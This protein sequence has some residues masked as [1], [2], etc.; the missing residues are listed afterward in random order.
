MNQRKR[1]LILLAFVSMALSTLYPLAGDNNAALAGGSWSAWI[2]NHDTGEMVHVFPDG[3]APVSMMF[4]LPPGSNFNLPSEVTISRDGALLAACLYD[5][6]GSA[7]VFAQLHQDQS[8]GAAAKY[9][10]VVADVNSNLLDAVNAAADGF[11]HCALK[12]G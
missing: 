7:G 10:D 1:L 2:Y 6:S 3:A 4:P 8:D 12:I 9:Q 5:D 11:D